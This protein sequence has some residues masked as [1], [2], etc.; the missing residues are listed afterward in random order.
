M[1]C[2]GKLKSPKTLDEKAYE[3]ILKKN[4]SNIR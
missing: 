3:F 4:N 2:V 1:E